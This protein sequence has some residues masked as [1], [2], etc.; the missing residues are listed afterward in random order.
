MTKEF[1]RLTPINECKVIEVIEVKS[2]VGNGTH[3]SPIVEITEY[4]SL[5]GVRLARYV[6]SE[7]ELAPG[8]WV[9]GWGEEQK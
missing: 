7:T 8:V 2:L 1:T 9:N 4:Y 3:E 6:P 5:D